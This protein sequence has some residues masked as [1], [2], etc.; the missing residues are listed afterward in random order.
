MNRVEAHVLD[1]VAQLFPDP[2]Q[3]LREWVARTV[4]SNN[5]LVAGKLLAAGSLLLP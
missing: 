4:T 5:G 1:L 2:V 3:R